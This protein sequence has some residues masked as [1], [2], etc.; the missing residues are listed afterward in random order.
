MAFLLADSRRQI[1][2]TSYAA[3]NS[4]TLAEGTHNSLQTTRL[5]R[6]KSNYETEK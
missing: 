6:R 3:Q 1:D 5:L 4:C 2:L